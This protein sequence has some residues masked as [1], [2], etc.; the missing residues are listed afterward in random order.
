MHYAITVTTVKSINKTLSH[1]GF[2]HWLVIQGANPFQKSGNSIK[3]W[4]LFKALSHII[5]GVYL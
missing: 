2:D 1:G 5:M 3:F 4:A